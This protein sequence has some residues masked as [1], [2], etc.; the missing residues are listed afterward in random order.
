MAGLDWAEGAIRA[1]AFIGA[2]WADYDF[3]H[4]GGGFSQDEL[5]LGAYAGWYGDNFWVRGTVG[6]SWLKH[7][8]DRHIELGASVRRHSGDADGTNLFGAV[9]GGYEFRSEDFTH[10]PVAGLVAQRVRVDGFAEDQ[11]TLSTSLAFPDQDFDSLIGSIG[12]RAEMSLGTAVRP[13][14]QLTLDK[15]LGDLDEE[16]YAQLQ[17]MSETTPYA[18]PGLSFDDSYVTGQVGLKGQ[19][20]AV[21]AHIGGNFT[22]LNDDGNIWG[23]RA[24]V[25]VKF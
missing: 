2:G 12:Y 23:I 18:V 22:A 4:F 7:D 21:N 1:G 5:T 6:H 10:G 9:Q 24:G 25:G 13:Y 3:D 8:I 16:V 14:V 19:F 17:S 11:P 20:G 15:E